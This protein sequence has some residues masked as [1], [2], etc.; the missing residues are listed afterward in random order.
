M[1]QSNLILE[2]IWQLT[3]YQGC[4]ALERY[5]PHM[6]KQVYQSLFDIAP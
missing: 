3:R 1:R 4:L 6:S 2:A 5:Q